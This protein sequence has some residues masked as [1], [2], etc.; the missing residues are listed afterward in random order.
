MNYEAVQKALNAA[1]AQPQLVTD[2][3]WG[4]KS[5]TALTAYQRS[6]GLVA[7]GKLGPKSLQSLGLA[8]AAA[9]PAP[10]G[11]AKAAPKP[12]A[13]NQHTR[14][15]AIVDGLGLT[16]NQS[17]LT[18]MVAWHETNNGQ[19]WK[20]GEGAGSFNMG[21]ITTK[22]AGAPNFQHKD[23]RND[24][25]KIVE[26]VT[27]FKGYPSFTAGMKGLAD[28]LLK[29]NVKAALAKDDFAGAVAAMYE[30]GYF[31]GLNR[32][33]TPEGNKNNVADYVSA[34]QKAWGTIA[35]GTGETLP[36]GGSAWGIF[37]AAAVPV[38]AGAIWLWWK[39]K[40]GG[41]A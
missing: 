16:P 15:K 41:L 13:D 32:R 17:K 20:Q 6:H 34:T 2:G 28:F 10:G 24:K 29:P 19:G 39:R 11:G 38:V 33:D 26:Y 21:A 12:V 22:T 3:K 37:L 18:R 1:G 31:T 40:S 27:W 14:A 9:A 35:A 36:G 5:I 8:D 25:G 4:P 23:S 7:D 30:N